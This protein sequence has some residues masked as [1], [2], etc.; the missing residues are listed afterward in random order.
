M[1][2][3]QWTGVAAAVGERSI[4]ADE[5]PVRSGGARTGP[6][7]MGAGRMTESN[8]HSG[9]GPRRSRSGR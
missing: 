2:V 6:D 3:V 8:E 9:A 5:A 7:V 1:W 4:P